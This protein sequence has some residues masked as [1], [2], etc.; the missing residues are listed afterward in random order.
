MNIDISKLRADRRALDRRIIALKQ[1]LRAT[2][3]EPMA[4]RQRELLACKHEATELCV[5]R[6]WGRGRL[7]LADRDRCEAI[8]E[9]R[10]TAY[11]LRQDGAA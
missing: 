9:R 4:D 10:A 1:V 8:A 11:R 7:H 5:L 3:T 6:A 2:W